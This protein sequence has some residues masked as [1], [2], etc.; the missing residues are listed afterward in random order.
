M[1]GANINSRGEATVT[2]SQGQ[3]RAALLQWEHMH[4]NGQTL[5]H[6]ESDKLPPEQVADRGCE[7][8]WRLLVHETH[9]PRAAIERRGPGQPEGNPA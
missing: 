7:L 5:G 8:L 2:V 4:R 1:N 6:E 9:E 3:L